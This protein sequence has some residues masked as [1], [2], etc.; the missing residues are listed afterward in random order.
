MS[1]NDTDKHLVGHQ[2][3]NQIIK[4][5]PRNKFDELVSKHRSDPY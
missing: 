1:S 2:V 5:I 4:F 3:L